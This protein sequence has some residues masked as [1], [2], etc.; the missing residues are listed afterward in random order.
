MPLVDLFVKPDIPK[1]FAYWML[2]LFTHDE[3]GAVI[4]PYL[5]KD[6]KEGNDIALGYLQSMIKCNQQLKMLKVLMMTFTNKDFTELWRWKMK[7]ASNATNKPF[8]ERIA[9]SIH[10]E[11][12]ARYAELFGEGASMPIVLT[13]EDGTECTSD[14]KLLMTHSRYLQCTLESSE[15]VVV[16]MTG[17]ELL[18][19]MAAIRNTRNVI[20][21]RPYG[22]RTAISV[23]DHARVYADIVIVDWMLDY[24]QYYFH[25]FKRE[26]ETQMALFEL[27]AIIYALPKCWRTSVIGCV[28]H[29]TE[30]E[31]NAMMWKGHALAQTL[32]VVRT[33]QTIA[34]GINTDVT[35][36]PAL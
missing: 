36:S 31:F 20:T 35:L 5:S 34:Q 33:V 27:G 17:D 19:M 12:E 2:L 24:I 8:M 16:G 30:R 11:G 18:L 26:A 29:F 32:R 15:G 28:K 7:S 1:N 3:A 9:A 6:L 10:K 23:L 13:T 22:L 25:Q 4:L 14:I 21:E